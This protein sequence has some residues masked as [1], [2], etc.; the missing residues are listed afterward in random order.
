MN[1]KCRDIAGFIE[2][3]APR[4]LAE[5][6]DNV[7]LL[8]GSM[9]NDIKRVLLALDV[10]VDTVDE[11]AGL[12]AEMI[13]SHH[14][15][16]F[17]GM[18]TIVSDDPKGNLAARLIRKDICVFSAHTNLD[19]AEGGVND[20]LALRLGLSGNENFKDYG[21]P[22]TGGCQYGLGKVG[23]LEKGVELQGFIEMVKEALQVGS[24]KAVGREGTAIKKVAVFCG[25]FDDDLEAFR[26]SGADVLVTGDLKYHTALDILQMGRCA[27]D[28][29]HFNTERVILP[30]LAERLRQRFNEL[31]VFCST[32]G[33]DPFTTY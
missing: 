10:T 16:I 8:A 11:A 20:I 26:R 13:I 30:V 21:L 22:G 2:E 32:L 18:K 19:V 24:V 3:I 6:W 5:G 29:G 12:G 1:V 15:F 4:R 31:E 23:M 14:P 7:G 9:E 33:K 25:S 28:A 27:V 17:K